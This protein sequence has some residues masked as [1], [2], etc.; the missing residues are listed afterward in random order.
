MSKRLAAIACAFS[1]L[2]LFACGAP[3]DGGGTAGV[4]AGETVTVR[5]EEFKFDP[6]DLDAPAAPFTVR[7]VNEGEVAHNW[8]VFRRDPTLR[9]DQDPTKVRSVAGTDSL[10]PGERQTVRVDLRPGR[11]FIRS[12]I[13][14]QDT[15]GMKGI[16][17]IRSR[18]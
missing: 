6:R 12:T 14:N 2:A 10:P 9:A 4:S 15:L 3:F 1:A 18:R 13:G 5:M 8:K 16:L 17:R 11:Y 7:V